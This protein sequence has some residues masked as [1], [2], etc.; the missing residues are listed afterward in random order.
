[1]EVVVC[2]C[3]LGLLEDH[4]EDPWW[5]ELIAEVCNVEWL[6]TANDKVQLIQRNPNHWRSAIRRV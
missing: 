5:S 6:H 1:M 4:R 3:V 2:L